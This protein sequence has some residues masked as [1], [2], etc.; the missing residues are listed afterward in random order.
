M[1][2]LMTAPPAEHSVDDHHHHHHHHHHEKEAPALVEVEKE[3][4]SEHGRGH[5]R[6]G[7][8]EAL[9]ETALRVEEDHDEINDLEAQ[10]RREVEEERLKYEQMQKEQQHED[11]DAEYDD[12]IFE[13]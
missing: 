10:L 12:D 2:A 5:G 9:G 6:E 11:G 8:E 7:A 1:D 3:H 13:P 4:E